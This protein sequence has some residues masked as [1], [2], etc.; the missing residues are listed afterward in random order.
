[1]NFFRRFRWAALLAA[2]SLVVFTAEHAGARGAES[3]F[4][5]Y[6]GLKFSMRCPSDRAT[7][8]RFRDYGYW[9]GGAWCGRSDAPAGY[10]VWSAPTWYVWARQSGFD[11]TVGGKYGDLVATLTCPSDRKT[12]GS[13]RDYGFWNGGQW[14]GQD[15]PSG[16]WVY[17]APTWYIFARA[18]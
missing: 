15:G 5:K 6:R 1:M 11:A 9:G 17:I 3:A 13:F 14:C 2:L 7:Y 18:N 8:G 12:Y 4:G 16:Y 10:W